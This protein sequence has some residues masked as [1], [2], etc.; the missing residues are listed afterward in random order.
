MQQGY[1]FKLIWNIYGLFILF[2]KCFNKRE[3]RITVKLIAFLYTWNLKKL[4]RVI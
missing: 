3:K 2:Y 4:N 1:R